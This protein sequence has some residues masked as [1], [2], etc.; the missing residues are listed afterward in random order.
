VFRLLRVLLAVAAAALLLIALL[1]VWLYLNWPKEPPGPPGVTTSWR[2]P[3]TLTADHP[4]AVRGI[5]VRVDSRV[6]RFRHP[7]LVIGARPTVPNDWSH[8]SEVWLSIFDPATGDAVPRRAGA[9]H[10]TLDLLTGSARDLTE[11]EK[12]S[13]SATYAF[14]IRWLAPVAGDE[15][16]V[17]MDARLSATLDV[18]SYPTPATPIPTGSPEGLSLTDDESLRFDGL[19]A[20]LVARTSGDTRITSEQPIAETHLLLHVPADALQ[21]DLGYPV[22][23]R[24]LLTVSPA[25]SSDRALLL[26]KE[27][28]VP[29]GSLS[30]VAGIA[31]DTEWL[32]ACSPGKDCDVP[33]DLRFAF[34]GSTGPGTTTVRADAWAQASWALEVHL[35][36]LLTDA[37]LPDSELSLETVAP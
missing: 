11:C 17:T 2:Q 12:A 20:T 10:A 4:V 22:I 27:L 14:V 13:C 37:R 34:G 33:F 24:A 26:W 36:R 21:G 23:G 35:E 6:G 28:T 30:G 19:P 31:S 25:E 5:S 3:I 1:F 18:P 8:A 7:N 16:R 15:V 9:G 29:R 32:S